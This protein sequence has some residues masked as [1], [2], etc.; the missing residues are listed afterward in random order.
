[1]TIPVWFM[2]VDGVL[3][4]FPEN[5]VDALLSGIQTFKASPNR[6]PG[7]S[8][9]EKEEMKRR[10]GGLHR[11]QITYDPSIIERIKALH[12]S[13]VVK[14]VWLTT[15]GIGANGELRAGF[16]FPRFKIAGDPEIDATTKM[17]GTILTDHPSR[18]WKADCVEKYLVKN[19]DV[20]SFVWT[21][22]DLDLNPSVRDWA[23]KNGGHV[24]CP[25]YTT[26]LTH[27]DL[28]AI[29][30]YLTRDVHLTE[31]GIR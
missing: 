23:L 29:E 28:D 18:W 17:D 13:G 19:S 14:V 21:D 10:R 8:E 25:D 5:H 16:N 2:D 7:M 30:A 11:Y 9:E 20:T 4:M 26:G 27:E 3:N 1:M 24:L 22:D 15:W 31:D 6:W 12:E